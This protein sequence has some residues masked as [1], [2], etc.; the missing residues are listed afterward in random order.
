LVRGRL[1][2]S[3]L[4]I[5][6][7]GLTFF[8]LD[9]TAEMQAQITDLIVSIVTGVAGILALISKVREQARLEK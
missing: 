6:A 5:L 1:G 2:A 7:F 3:L 9:F 4:A 8:N